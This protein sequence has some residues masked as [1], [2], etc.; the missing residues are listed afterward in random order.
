MRFETS[1][2]VIRAVPQTVEDM[3][4]AFLDSNLQPR[5]RFEIGEPFN[6]LIRAFFDEARLTL[7]TPQTVDV[8]FASGRYSCDTVV[9]PAQGIFRKG[10]GKSSTEAKAEGIDASSIQKWSGNTLGNYTAFVR[11]SDGQSGVLKCASRILDVV[12][13]AKPPEIRIVRPAETQIRFTDSASN[14]RIEG[15]V[16]DTGSGI[17][18]VI[19]NNGD[20]TVKARL[21]SVSG[22]SSKKRFVA[23][24]PYRPGLHLVTVTAS[25]RSG[26]RARDAG[27]YVI[28]QSF[29]P[30]ARQAGPD[31][32]RGQEDLQQRLK[33]LKNNPLLY[34]LQPGGEVRL[35]LGSGTVNNEE[36][37]VD[38]LNEVIHQTGGL[39]GP[40]L[41][42]RLN[43]GTQVV[44]TDPSLG[45]F[46]SFFTGFEVEAESLILLLLPDIDTDIEGNLGEPVFQIF[47]NFDASIRIPFDLSI[48]AECQETDSGIADSITLSLDELACFIGLEG[49]DG[50]VNF[51]AAGTFSIGASLK[52]KAEDGLIAYFNWSDLTFNH[53]FVVTNGAAIGFFDE[54][55]ARGLSEN[56]AKEIHKQFDRQIRKALQKAAGCR[57]SGV[58]ECT[59]EE[60]FVYVK[61]VPAKPKELLEL[62]IYLNKE[63]SLYTEIER[64]Y[65]AP[66]NEGSWR[67]DVLSLFDYLGNEG[68][69]TNAIVS[70]F[71]RSR[72]VTEEAKLGLLLDQG[73][74]PQPS[75][76]AKPL[77]APDFNTIYGTPSTDL[78]GALNINAINQ[79]LAAYWQAGNFRLPA[80]RLN[81]LFNRSGHYD[82]IAK[83]LKRE[84]GRSD[85]E[86]LLIMSGITLEARLTQPP[87]FMSYARGSG[88]MYLEVGGIEWEIVTGQMVGGR[89]APGGLLNGRLKGKAGVISKATV[90][91]DADTGKIEFVLSDPRRCLPRSGVR[92]HPKAASEGHFKTGHFQEPLRAAS[93]VGCADGQYIENGKEANGFGAPEAGLVVSSDRARGGS[94]TREDCPL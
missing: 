72:N 9:R 7:I 75:V 66:L 31:S 40:L 69:V 91:T 71:I 24:L 59:P 11:Y 92:G 2:L 63:E 37:G 94:P 36:P 15:T 83:K 16:A 32:V 62:G 39:A 55:Q 87:R 19:V 18:R 35:R 51:D 45:A 60:D 3:E 26:R 23:E 5:D 53:N 14:L 1:T 67:A 52:L 89:L 22:R 29:M 46:W 74:L 47:R 79:M 33:S 70:P 80:T 86:I 28:G 82:Q 85:F 68:G 30:L 57:R 34:K 84:S 43:I 90:S 49:F 61:T 73:R 44:E 58:S 88:G 81:D 41:K 10:R 4:I 27:A 54:D 76:T 6:I 13:D 8:T 56:V 78:N 50:V 17:A 93:G 20:D 38:S 21:Y 42:D 25:D 48:S 65:I 64:D 77:A 12:K